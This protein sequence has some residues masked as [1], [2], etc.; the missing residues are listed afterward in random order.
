MVDC[1][2]TSD[3]KE[4]SDP[5]I[6]SD[7]EI[8]SDCRAKPTDRH[9]PKET[10]A[11]EEKE[12]SDDLESD[13][14]RRMQGLPTQ[15]EG[16]VAA[17]VK[18][19]DKRKRETQADD[20]GDE[21]YGSALDEVLE[22]WEE[23]PLMYKAGVLAKN[24]FGSKRRKVEGEGEEGEFDGDGEGHEGACGG[25]NDDVKRGKEES[26]GLR[27]SSVKG[28]GRGGKDDDGVRSTKVERPTSEH[29]K[30]EKAD[31]DAEGKVQD[32]AKTTEEVTNEARARRLRQNWI[33]LESLHYTTSSHISKNDSN[34]IHVAVGDIL[35]YG[36]L[37]K[38][39][40]AAER[41]GGAG[42]NLKWTQS[43]RDLLA[44]YKALRPDVLVPVRK[45]SQNAENTDPELELD[46]LT[47]GKIKQS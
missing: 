2:V 6:V 24:V 34:H 5:E 1:D 31:D 38:K 30:S 3:H 27:D 4:A 42:N 41:A 22:G 18:A 7:R 44:A 39:R 46:D 17:I 11:L 47:K 12:K 14:V 45:P 29:G 26:V 13:Q 19:G 37:L 32:E 20:L 28:G 9:K 33:G 36:K 23:V 10:I 25:V 15:D 21:Q 8:V 43:M 16:R 40:E 35:Y